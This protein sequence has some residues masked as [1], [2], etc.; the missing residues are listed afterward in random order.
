MEQIAKHFLQQIAAA[1]KA[2]RYWV[3]LSGGLDSSVLL[4]LA[5]TV[6]PHLS[7]GSVHVHH[8]LQ[9][10]ADDWALR[11]QELANSLGVTHKTFRVQVST[12]GD[13]SV[14][15]A[16]R[17]A[18][19]GVFS[20][21]VQPGE[22]LLLAHHL[23]DQRE[24]IMMRMLR[25]AGSLGLQ[26]M[27]DRRNLGQ[28][29]LL[30]PLL[31]LPRASLEAYCREHGLK[32]VEDPSNSDLQ[33][34]RN[35]LR[36]RVLPAVKKRW[37]LHALDR[38]GR[39]ARESQTLARDLAEIDSTQA[40]DSAGFLRVDRVASLSRVRQTNLLRYWIAL[41][42]HPLPSEAVVNSM[43]QSCVAAKADAQPV[44]TWGDLELRRFQ[45]RLLILP[46]ESSQGSDTY[47]WKSQDRVLDLA[48]V[49]R[50]GLTQGGS[51]D[52]KKLVW[53]LTVGFRQGG[54]RIRPSVAGR[55]R[56][57][58]NLFNEHGVFPWV[59]SRIPLI[60]SDQR[61]VA[62]ADLW[63]DASVATAPA[64]EGFGLVWE[65][66]FDVSFASLDCG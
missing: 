53:P 1:P 10:S 39:H 58:K 31:D 42:G 51:I 25:G 63:C 3:G 41:E 2:S 54:E 30:R 23:D 12:S 8:G 66:D 50:L 49:G 60:F 5:A 22:A 34:D 13:Q 24:T 36:H 32:T 43:L 56:T 14:E 19:F 33:F 9:A 29:F 65:R 17:E 28:G 61:L 45:G 55:Q 48:A 15:E 38:V 44:V 40:L 4:H 46:S 7:I 37:S 64:G 11:C 62:V 57:L 59:R 27:P 26:G 16:A 35:Y 20:Q 6:A 52:P 18:R 21:L 47:T